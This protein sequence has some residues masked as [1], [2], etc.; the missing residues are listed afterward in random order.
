MPF[1]PSLPSTSLEETR[2]RMATRALPTPNNPT[3]DNYAILLK[4]SVESSENGMPTLIGTIGLIQVK[5]DAAELG[6]GLHPDY[7]GKGYGT[8]AL[9]LFFNY[10]WAPGSMFPIYILSFLTSKC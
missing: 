2:V 4:S 1:R 7:W 9:K 10:Y 5:V 6:Y 3:V 8:E